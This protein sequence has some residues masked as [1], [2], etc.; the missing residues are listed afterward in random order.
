MNWKFW[1]KPKKADNSSQTNNEKLPRPKSI[2]EP[3]GRYL[4]VQMGKDPDWVWNLR[5]A[6]RTRQE[7]PNT[8]YFRV[9]DPSKAAASRISVR[10]YNQ[11]EKY[12]QLILFAG[13]YDKK[14][15]DV[16][17]EEEKKPTPVSKAA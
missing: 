14:L 16:H 10:D 5:A 2:P 6:I 4:V 12:P 15:F 13:W 11:L 8:Y 7:K 17:M 9:F 3:V 1:E